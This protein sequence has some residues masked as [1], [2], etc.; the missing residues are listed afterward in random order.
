MIPTFAASISPMS[1]DEF[2]A[3]QRG[4]APVYFPGTPAK[5]ADLLNTQDLAEVLSRLVVSPGIVRIRRPDGGVPAEDF[6]TPI[7]PI[8]GSHRQVIRAQSVEKQL[9][10]GATL[11][12]ENCESHFANVHAMC[13]ML[14]EVFLV[15][16]YAFLFLVY[17]PERPCGIHWDNYDMFICQV[18]GC[19]KWPIYKPVYRSPVLFD[20][21]RSHYDEPS[22]E[23]MQEFRLEPGDALYVP[24]GWPHDPVGVG[25][26]SL[27]IAFAITTPTGIDLLDWIR[28]DLSKTCEDLRVDLPLSRSQD[29]KRAY[30]AKFR[31]ILLN[32]LSDDAIDS[33][34]E[35]HCLNV[36]EK[37]VQLPGLS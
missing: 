7:V 19:K 6:L 36:R 30:A 16:V 1:P 13:S 34:Y 21:R 3:E 2:L 28:T 10:D 12:L 4:K 11:T 27:H 20:P 37:P 5:Y 33:Y 26:A 15:R 23:L 25:G 24:R 35:Q 29:A 14:S 17:E 8:V 9:K 18:A 22:S 32:R 31:Q